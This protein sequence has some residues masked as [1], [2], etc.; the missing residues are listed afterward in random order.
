N[1]SKLW[2]TCRPIPAVSAAVDLEALNAPT[3]DRECRGQITDNVRS[4]SAHGLAISTDPECRS[5][6]GGIQGLLE[7]R[8]RP[9]WPWR[10][11]G[12]HV[13]A[14]ETLNGNDASGYDRHW[15]L[16][17]LMCARGFRYPFS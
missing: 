15:R 8:W 13:R 17:E 7:E 1:P 9:G 3:A 5:H 14:S 16:D 11:F 6:S 10:R 4:R 12:G 2:V